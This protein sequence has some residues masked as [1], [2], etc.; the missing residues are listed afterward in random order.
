MRLP[1]RVFYLVARVYFTEKSRRAAEA[2]REMERY[3]RL[4]R[5]I[6]ALERARHGLGQCGG[7]TNGCRFRPCYVVE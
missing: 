1:N 7:A 5:W 2:R 3:E 4:L 6:F